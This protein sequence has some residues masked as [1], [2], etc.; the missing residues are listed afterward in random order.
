[1]KKYISK[2]VVLLAVALSFSAATEAQLRVIIRPSITIGVRPPQPSPRHV[3]VSGE[4]NSNG[5][6]YDYREGYWSEPRSKRHRYSEGHWRHS[7]RGYVW[8]PGRWR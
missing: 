3:W 8:V 2:I 7:R 4:W 6:R 1:M 5:G